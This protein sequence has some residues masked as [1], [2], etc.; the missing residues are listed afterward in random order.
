MKPHQYEADGYVDLEDEEVRDEKGHLVDDAYVARVVAAAEAIRSV[1]NPETT[2]EQR[3][4][5]AP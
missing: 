3:S 1:R 4:P 2:S 5:A